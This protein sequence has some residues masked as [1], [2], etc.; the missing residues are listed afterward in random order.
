MLA[1]VPEQGRGSG[2]SRPDNEKKLIGVYCCAQVVSPIRV[3]PPK[4]YTRSIETMTSRARPGVPPVRTPRARREELPFPTG[5]QL[6]LLRAALLPDQQ[7]ATAWRRWKARGL[8]L[9]SVDEASARMLSQL[10]TNRDAAMIDAADSA[11]LMGIYRHALARNAVTLTNAL[12]AT[13]VLVSAGIPVL[14]FKGAAMIA[15]T[16]GH[17]GAR[18]IADADILIPETD[19]ARAVALLMAAGYDSLPGYEI[20]PPIGL[21]HAWAC[22]G[23]KG[24]ELDVHWWA[25]KTAGDDT[26]MFETARE[27]TILGRPVLIPSV[28]ETL[29]NV[30]ANAFV[31][32]TGGS[33]L[34]WIADALLLLQIEGGKIDWE[35]LVTRTSRPGLTLR[36]ASGLR[37]LAREFEAPVPADVLTALHGQRVPWQERG[38]YW[39]AVNDPRVGT[40]LLYQLEQHRARRLH[41]PTGVPRDFLGHLA[42]VARPMTGKRRDVLTSRALGVWQR[43]AK[44]EPLLR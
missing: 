5:A 38:A 29:V 28:T 1:E 4:P 12:E 39:A 22:K 19:A 2:L 17:L 36:L 34:R 35:G 6:D 9:E 7:A 25:F 20:G 21:R 24:S 31:S 33:P 3:Y 11:L 40:R 32:P 26:S 27:A 42:Q 18:R 15:I 41:Y 10:W 16:P 37:F 44:G 14:F 13:D 8:K 30:I 23:P 43:L